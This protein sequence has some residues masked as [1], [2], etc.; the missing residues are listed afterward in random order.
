MIGSLFG[1]SQMKSAI[2]VKLGRRDEQLVPL[3]SGLAAPTKASRLGERARTFVGATRIARG[4]HLLTLASVHFSI[5]HNLAS[6]TL[7]RPAAPGSRVAK[8]RHVRDGPARPLPP[9]A[10]TWSDRAIVARAKLFHTIQLQKRL[11]GNQRCCHFRHELARWP[12]LCPVNVEAIWP[13]SS[14]IGAYCDFRASC[15][16]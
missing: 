1:S 13:K 4:R 12:T 10:C 14:S 11:V 2:A 7:C 6:L 9:P 5:S 15:W 16:R 3:P 8:G